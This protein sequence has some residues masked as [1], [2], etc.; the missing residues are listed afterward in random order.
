MEKSV[1]M[2]SEELTAHNNTIVAFMLFG[3]D[4]KNINNC[5]TPQAIINKTDL[6]RGA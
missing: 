1:K 3:L 5:R 6:G 4:S 2:P